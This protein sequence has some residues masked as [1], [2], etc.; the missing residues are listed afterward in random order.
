MG[1][2]IL[3]KQLM[4]KTRFEALLKT[5]VSKI[6]SQEMRFSQPKVAFTYDH[7]VLALRT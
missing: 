5:T 7:E 3:Q 2:R 1:K 6:D 4:E